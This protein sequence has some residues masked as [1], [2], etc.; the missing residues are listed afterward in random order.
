MIGGQREHLPHR[1]KRGRCRTRNGM[2]RGQSRNCRG[3]KVPLALRISV[4][5]SVP[6]GGDLLANQQHPQPIDRQPSRLREEQ[7]VYRPL[8]SQGMIGDSTSVGPMPVATDNCR[9]SATIAQ[10]P[11]AADGTVQRQQPVG[12]AGKI[13]PHGHHGRTPLSTPFRRHKMPRM[14]RLPAGRNGH[15]QAELQFGAAVGNVAAEGKSWGKRRRFCRLGGEEIAS[16]R[17]CPCVITA[18]RSADS[19][20]QTR[21]A[22]NAGPEDERNGSRQ[23]QPVH[24][25]S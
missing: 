9:T 8:G 1:A 22:D 13:A 6:K 16:A 18:C 7:P 11:I 17:L 21:C 20:T 4:R 10:M 2:R 24:P 14:P 5:V 12:L 3:G 23:P 15:R 25:K 19:P